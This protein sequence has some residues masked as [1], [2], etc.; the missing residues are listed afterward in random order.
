MSLQD[1]DPKA[2]EPGRL[3]RPAPHAPIAV[4]KFGSS[5]L[6]SP[7]DIPEVVSEIY[8]HVRRG[9]KVIA[10]VSAFLGRTDALLGQARALGGARDNKHLPRF[11][12]QGEE[13]AAALTAIGCDRVGLDV[14]A[15]SVRELG[16]VADGSPEDASPV[17][18]ESSALAAALDAHEVVVV[19]GYGAINEDDEVVLLGRGGTDLTAV[20][21]AAEL[22]LGHVR[23][24]KDVD[25]V[26]DS[27]PN[28]AGDVASRYAELD[29][30]TARIV[31]GKLVQRR[32]VEVAEQRRVVVE[33]AALGR[34]AASLIGPKLSDPVAAGHPRKWRV[35]LAGCGVVGGGVLQRLLGRPD[36]YE[37]TGVLVRDPSKPRDVR[38]PEGLVTA[39]AEHLFD[40]RPDVLVEAMSEGPPAERLIRRALERGVHVVSA[41]KQ[42]VALDLPG[43][44]ETAAAH[45]VQLSYSAAVGGGSPMIETVR[46]A[47]ALGEIAEVEA[48]LNGTVN[49][50]LDRLSHGS[51]F[52]DALAD[53]R[54]AGFAEEDPS[55]D[56]EGH[57]AA[58]KLRILAFEAFGQVLN[59]TDI[60]R[61]VL[62]ADAVAR[63]GGC[64][65]LRQIGR[66]VREDDRVEAWV[67]LEPTLEARLFRTLRGERNA[68]RVVLKDGRSFVCR[69]RGAGRWPTAESVFADL[70]ELVRS[71][72]G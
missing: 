29:W 26:Y 59:D 15:L 57:D 52:D 2:Y 7:D 55:A 68:L 39:D 58:A 20:F 38:I 60:P 36:L 44:S 30:K 43:L 18:L 31:A 28:I 48:V 41:N 21:L 49:F 64:G 67:N 23:L 5:V 65:T 27:D 66:C 11:V 69:G 62:N 4:L 35:A 70:G 19:P 16:I 1:L 61:P 50:M 54:A 25:G 33:V 24:L 10:V 13:Q 47:R 3:K 51:A 71:E 40:A 45:G 22:D 53:A 32:A 34:E 14:R 9:E 12:V 17:R 56:L 63:H 42:A 6:R 72:G 37:V 8:R 46:A